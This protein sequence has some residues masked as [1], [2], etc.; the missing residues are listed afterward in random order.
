VYV[1]SS[2][3]DSQLVE[4]RGQPDTTGVLSVEVVQTFVN[5][6][7]ILDFCV[8]DLGTRGHIVTCSVKDGSLRILRNGIRI[9]ELAT[10]TE[11]PGIKRIWSLQSSTLDNFDTSL[12]MSF[13]GETRIL[14]INSDDELEETEIQGF[15]CN[16]PSLF[17]Q[18]AIHDQLVQ[19]T[20]DSVR[21]V[22]ASSRELLFEWRDPSVL[23]ITVATAN[24]TQVLLATRTGN[25]I[26]LE[27]EEG[28]L[29]E[30]RR[31]TIEFD[32]SCMDINP[33]GENVNRSELA[34]VGLWKDY[35]VRVYSLNNLQIIRR[36]HFAENVLPRSVLFCRF[37]GISYLLC[38]LGDGHLYNITFNMNSGKFSDE[39][40]ISL[41][42]KAINIKTI[43]Y[44]NT[45]YV[46]AASDRC[47][48]IHSSNLRLTYNIVSVEKINHMCSFHS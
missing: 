22:S 16:A 11:F 14:A 33:I 12:V 32:V 48:V 18:D 27:I 17:C 6:G 29:K 36:F 47:T 9:N 45:T 5:L 2:D 30:V 3:G 37:E 44:K 42:T 43:C 7:P 26:Y 35:G 41:G 10:S 1:G 21:L 19:V 8:V 40:K 13:L 24:S 15:V 31:V 39:K 28:I 25:L 46:L 4:L 20:A 23:S 34:A 38:G